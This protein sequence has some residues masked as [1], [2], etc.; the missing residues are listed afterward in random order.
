MAHFAEISPTN[1][2][3]RVIVIP[4]EQE[5][6]GQDFINNDLKLP[7][8]WVQTSYNETF[9]GKFAGKGDTYYPET[10]TFRE[11]MPFPGWVWVDDVKRWQAPV[12]A[13]NDGKP[14]I[15]DGSSTSWVEDTSG[16]AEI[17]P[18]E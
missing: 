18:A 9:G 8:R 13:P 11:P 17:T 10:N 14:Y 16:Q 7:G 15:W 3:K 1:I 12:A 4:D 6:R 2:V 5:H